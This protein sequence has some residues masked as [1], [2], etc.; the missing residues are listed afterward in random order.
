MSEENEWQEIWDARMF[1]LESAFGKCD[2]T[3]LHAMIPFGLG[4]DIGG[5]PDVV[6]FSDFTNG[7]LYV[8][9]DLIGCEDQKPNSHGNYEL[10]VAHQEDED[11]GID[12]ICRLAYYTIDNEIDDGETMDIGEAT[13]EGST[14][15]AFL[16][17][18]IA[19]F[20]FQGKP[21]N[22]IC[23]LGITKSE[24]DFCHEKG[25]E[26]LIDKLPQNYILTDL[27]RKSYV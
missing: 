26:A 9:T 6:S 13:P 3:H 5:S 23:C 22:V 11:W 2:E 8:T 27:Y 21:A 4:Q 19:S 10:A 20:D 25:T 7:K 16:F 17:K 14:I 24:L 15:E 18:R 12:I 1:G